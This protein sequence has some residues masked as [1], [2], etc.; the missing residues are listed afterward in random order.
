M[1]RSF[2]E[3]DTDGEAWLL[4]DPHGKEKRLR[5][6]WKRQQNNFLLKST[7]KKKYW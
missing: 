5:K 2:G 4:Y 7:R 3:I 1:R 6:K